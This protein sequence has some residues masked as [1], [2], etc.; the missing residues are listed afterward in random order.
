[1]VISAGVLLMFLVGGVMSW[2]LGW[3]R[4]ETSP[5]PPNIVLEAELCPYAEHGEVFEG[6]QPLVLRY[7]D[8]ASGDE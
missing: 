3:N 5:T 4:L 7:Q 8:E 1:M 6:D 2:R